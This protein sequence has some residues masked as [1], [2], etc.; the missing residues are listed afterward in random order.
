M[1]K[2]VASPLLCYGVRNL[3][4]VFSAFCKPNLFWRHSLYALSQARLPRF[5]K[6][7]VEGALTLK[8]L[9]SSARY[10][11][12]VQ[13]ANTTFFQITRLSMGATKDGRRER[14]WGL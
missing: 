14:V 13:W 4:M 9:I 7:S 1:L 3:S 10:L 5:N 8:Q 2:V 11:H 6:R 12:F